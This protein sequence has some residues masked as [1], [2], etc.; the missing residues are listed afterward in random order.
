MLV[1]LVKVERVNNIRLDAEI[2]KKETI[3]I[4]IVF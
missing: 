4:F 3:I 1:W 2:Q